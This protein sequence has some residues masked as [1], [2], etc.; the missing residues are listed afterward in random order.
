MWI[1]NQLPDGIGRAAPVRVTSIAGMTPNAACIFEVGKAVA[2]A[3][4][5]A[6]GC[7]M[8]PASATRF[9][10]HRSPAD[11]IDRRSLDRRTAR[12]APPADA[13]RPPSRGP[14]DLPRAG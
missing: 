7:D 9:L 8:R 5:I 3:A 6:V 10:S 4:R 2:A 11:D 12:R 13:R 14:R 1:V